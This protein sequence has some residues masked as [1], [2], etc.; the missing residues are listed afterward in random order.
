MIE[1]TAE[2]IKANG[3]MVARVSVPRPGGKPPYVNRVSLD[4]DISRKRFAETAAG[5]TDVNAAEVEEELLRI[6]DE[7]TRQPPL[8]AEAA[9]SVPPP[10]SPEEREE[11]ESY[12][13]QP[14]LFNRIAADVET[15]GLTGERELGLTLYLV[16][17]SRLQKKPLKAV[18]QGPSG[19]GKTYSEET[20]GRMMPSEAIFRATSLSDQAWYY[21]DENAIQHK[22]LILGEREQSTDPSRVDARRAWRELMVSDEASRVV[23]VSDPA[24]REPRTV[25][26]TVRGPCAFIETTTSESIVEEDASR[27]LPLRPCETEQQT[28]RIISRVAMDAAGLSASDEDREAILRRHH[29]VQRLL[30]EHTGIAIAIP[31]ALD[32]A[33]PTDQIVARR[34]FSYMLG[35]IRSVALLRIYQKPPELSR[36]ADLADYTIAYPLFRPLVMRQLSTVTDIDRDVLQ[37]LADSRMETFTTSQAAHLLGI[38]DRQARRRTARLLSRDL[39]LETESSRRNRREYQLSDKELSDVDEGLTPPE[40]LQ[41]ALEEREAIQSEHLYDL[42]LAAEGVSDVQ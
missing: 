32:I 41:D 23:T 25:K 31:Y 14:D 36:Q 30:A 9:E 18:L 17:T 34:V 4:S 35:M 20:V 12:L 1:L 15:M 11:A 16:M 29:A 10:L 19:L 7:Q 42:S 37:R 21:L 6:I 8:E 33:I 27:M 5:L 2:M 24:T 13:R 22:V 3:Q 40:A 26:K 39:I 28:K 38:S